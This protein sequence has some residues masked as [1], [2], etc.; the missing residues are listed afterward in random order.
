[1]N[2]DRS[3]A[4]RRDRDS[5]LLALLHGV[6]TLSDFAPHCECSFARICER[7]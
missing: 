7:Y 2:A 1:M 6:D 3:L 4:E 5:L